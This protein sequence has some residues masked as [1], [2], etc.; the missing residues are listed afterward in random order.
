MEHSD[1]TALLLPRAEFA[2]AQGQMRP[3]RRSGRG[4]CDWRAISVT[5]NG[6]LRAVSSGGR[7][8]YR[9]ET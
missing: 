3:C 6:A 8:R 9:P 5:V 2:E 1:D 7:R 4:L